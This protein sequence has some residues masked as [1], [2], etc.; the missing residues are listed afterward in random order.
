M[1]IYLLSWRKLMTN[2]RDYL[3]YSLKNGF[4][5]GVSTEDQLERYNALIEHFESY[6]CFI[7]ST[8]HGNYAF[9]YFECGRIN[10]HENLIRDCSTS[11]IIGKAD[12]LLV[13]L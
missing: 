8:C 5:F 13:Y 7:T 11:L 2:K 6:D 9:F 10:D 1:I 3:L 4:A 12:R